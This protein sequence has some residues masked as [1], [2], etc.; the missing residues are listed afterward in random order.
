M[1]T[2]KGNLHQLALNLS[3]SFT[4]ELSGPVFSEFPQ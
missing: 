1:L 2:V 3:H 4:S